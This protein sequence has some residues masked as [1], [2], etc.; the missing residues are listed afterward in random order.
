MANDRVI[1]SIS[2]MMLGLSC[3]NVGAGRD[4]RGRDKYEVK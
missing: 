1:W 4:Q 2:L 3:C